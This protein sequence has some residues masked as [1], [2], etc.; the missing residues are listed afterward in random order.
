MHTRHL[1]IAVLATGII[2]FF[3]FSAAAVNAQ[4]SQIFNINL[5][6]GIYGN[7]DVSNLQKFLASKSLYSGPITGNFLSLT[8]QAVK[9]FQKQNGINPVSGYFGPLTRA[10][11]NVSVGQT[12]QTPLQWGAYTGNNTTSLADFESLIGTK[13]DLFADFEDWSPE[14]FPSDYASS[15][16]SNGK[17]LVIFWEPQY[18]YDVIN[19]GSEDGYITQFAAA[20]KSYGYPIILIPFDEMNLNENAWGDPFL[21]STTAAKS[22]TPAKFIRAWQRVHDFFTSDTNVKFGWDVNNVSVPDIATNTISVYYPGDA[23]VD[24][25][26]V[27]GFNFGNPNQSFSAIFD[28]AVKQ[29]ET[30]NKPIYIFSTASYEYPEKADW[31]ANG[32]GTSIKEYPNIAGWIWFNQSDDK[33]DFLI[34]SD[35]SSLAVFKTV[36]P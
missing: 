12:T 16:G 1:T 5:H 4:S 28:S 14:N 33:N 10:K 34:D 36:I 30:Y 21:N 27:D 17:T 23:Y 20:A 8:L 3:G 32:L 29:L 9:D 7:A 26:G 6:Y 35:S 18:D 19:S 2:G 31:I 11:V 15:V 25:V 22:N 13:V 24:Y